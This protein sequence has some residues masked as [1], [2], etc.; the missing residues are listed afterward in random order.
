MSEEH[1]HSHDEHKHD[2]ALPTSSPAT[3]E[4]AGSQALSEALRSSFFIVKLVMVGLVIVFLGSGF[5]TVRQSERAVVLHFG[6]PVGDGNK[7][8]LGPGLHWSFPRPIDEIVRIPYS[9]I[10]TVKST[11]GWYYTTKELELN[12]ETSGPASLNPNVDGYTIT[13][14]ENIVH[15][16]AT[17]TYRVTD[18]IRFQFD[19]VN[20]ERSVQDALDNALIYASARFKADDILSRDIAHFQDVVK[21]RLNQVVEKQNLGIIVEQCQVQSRP[22]PFLKKDFDAVLAAVSTRQE[23][24]NN[25]ASYRNRLLNMASAEASSL[26][27]AAEAE[28]YSVVKSVTAEAE[29]FNALLPKYN[30]SPDLTLSILLNERIGRVL[31]NVQDKF[32]LPS[33]A[34]GKPRQVRVQLNREPKPL[35]VAIPPNNQAAGAMP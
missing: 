7:A 22:P 34:D 28:R 2:P 9:E 4:D 33:R 10:R 32:F 30:A 29:R 18:P 35:G 6:K 25:A 19:F 21:S 26:T 23:T 24:L 12:Y 20:A 13:A 11:T 27:N 31:T 8:L 3:P 5:F 14:E 16:R 15:T 17:L 1:G